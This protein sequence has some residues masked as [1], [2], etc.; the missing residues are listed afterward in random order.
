MSLFRVLTLAGA[1]F[2]ASCSK[3]VVTSSG[4]PV[5]VRSAIVETFQRQVANA[6]DAGDGDLETR[7]LRRQVAAAP[8]NLEA[9]LKLASRYETTG[10][11]EIAV[12]HYRLAAERFPDREEPVVNLARLLRRLELQGEAGQVL[13]RYLLGHPSAQA[14]AWA[15]I[16]R[17]ELG[18]LEAGERAHRLAIGRSPDPASYLHNNLGQNLLLQGR[19]AEAAAEFRRALDLDPRSGIARNNLGVALA[20]LPEAAVADWKASGDPATAHSNMAAV[21]IEQGRYPEARH[22]LERA[23]GYKPDHTAAISNLALVSELDGQ[24]AQLSAGPASSLWRRVANMMGKVL[25]TPEEKRDR[26]EPAAANGAAHVAA[27][28]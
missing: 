14:F 7:L 21:L 3:H 23:L 5:P 18:K 27:Q 9:R 12:E 17:D 24:P 11:P 25:L 1:L 4:R 15:G 16:I 10:F 20:A 6:A 28:N 19:S 22:Q 8:E 2:A 26:G 13:D